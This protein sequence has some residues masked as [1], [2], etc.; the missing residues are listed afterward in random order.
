MGVL[1]PFSLGHYQSEHAAVGANMGVEDRQERQSPNLP[2]SKVDSAIAI[3]MTN[4]NGVSLNLTASL[5][6]ELMALFLV[7]S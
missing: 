7:F 5:K 6:V 1:T 4:S 2:K 3:A